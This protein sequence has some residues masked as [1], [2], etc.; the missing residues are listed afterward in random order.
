MVN[1]DEQLQNLLQQREKIG[2][3]RSLKLADGLVDFCSNDYLG[4][5]RNEEIH[6]N[7]LTTLQSGT[8]KIGSGG[9]RLLA[10]NAS[11]HEELEEILKSVHQA[12]AALLFNSGYAA[13]MG[14]F[15]TVPQKGDTVLYDELIHACV[16]DGMRLSFA[17]KYSFKHNDVEHL[18][19]RLQ[20]AQGNV[21]VAIESVYSMDGDCAPLE[22]LVTLCEKYNANLVI[23][24]AHSTGSMGEKGAGLCVELGIQDRVY[25]RIHTFGKAIGA[26]GACVVGSEILKEYLINFSRQ[27]IYTTSLPEH[28]L[29]VLKEIYAYLSVNYQSLQNQLQQKIKLFK[30]EIKADRIDSDSSIQAI[31]I[32]GNE[33]VLEVAEKMNEDGFDVRSVKSP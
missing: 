31:L 2:L 6:Q 19:K 16:K 18:E 11:M 24:E 12:E 28:H 30:T 27:F 32:P 17:D 22:K 20:K 25:A 33:R 7:I 1:I 14:F 29:V 5:A 23:D 10:G 9:S 26:H 4:I 8:V 21:F 15:A 13:N 3:K